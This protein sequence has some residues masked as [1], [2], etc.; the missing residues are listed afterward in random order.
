MMAVG[1]GRLGGEHR[2]DQREVLNKRDRTVALN[3]ARDLDSSGAAE[4]EVWK[5]LR[6]VE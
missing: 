3:R 6:N 5:V 1:D 4:L 2:S